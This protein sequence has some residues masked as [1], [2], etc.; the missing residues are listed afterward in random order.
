[1]ESNRREILP[2]RFFELRS[3]CKIVFFKRAIS[4]LVLVLPATAMVIMWLNKAIMDIV[5]RCGSVLLKAL[6][7][8]PYRILKI[9]GSWMRYRFIWIDP[10]A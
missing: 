3:F 9:L 8:R 5:E 1:M 6:R 7:Y 2:F 4:L 10:F